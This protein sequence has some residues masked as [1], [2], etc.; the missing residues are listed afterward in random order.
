VGVVFHFLDKDLKVRS[1]L[2]GMKRVKGAHTGE[3]IAE[4]VIPIIDMMISSD[5]LGF[6]VGDNA[7]TNGTAIR[8]I[9]AHLRPDLKDPDCRRVRCLG[10]IINLAAKAFLF[11][12]DAD[13]FEEESQTKKQLS[14]LEAVRELWRQK[15]PVGKFH[16]TVS[17]IRKTPQRHEAFVNLCGNGITPDMIGTL[18][19]KCRI[20]M[21]RLRR[22]TANIKLLGAD[23]IVIADN[24][25]RWNSTFTSIQRGIKLYNKIQVFSTE[26]KDE[27]GE[28]F[29]LP[30]DWDVL[31]RLEIYLE[32]FKRV[33]KQLEGHAA[34]GHHGAIWEALPIME[35]LLKHLERLKQSIPRRDIRIWE[36]VNNS[37]AKLDEY[38]HLTDKN[39]AVYAAATL[40][41]PAMRTAHFRKTWTGPLENWV[42]VMEANC[43]EV[44]TTQFLP[45]LPKNTSSKTPNG[46]FMRNVMGLSQDDELDEFGR[47]DRDPTPI[48]DPDTFNFDLRKDRNDRIG[49]ITSRVGT[50]DNRF[51]LE[52]PSRAPCSVV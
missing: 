3:N 6:F 16:N 19:L 51:G 36:C 49:W 5:Q 43:R 1:L 47:Y 24:E 7:G 27:L 48:S 46:S 39:H 8:A 28:D 17:F 29:L 2:A 26:F 50:I 4:A 38:Y 32:P 23:L 52:T 25:T 31:R 34:D 11:G 9:L 21:P 35:Y 15:G 37:W 33:T 12:K 10:H 41:H 18:L 42:Q 40:L 30:E 14:K 44:W 45:H 20:S 13:A 22:N